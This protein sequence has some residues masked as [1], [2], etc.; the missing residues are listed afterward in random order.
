MNFRDVELLSAYLDGQLSPSEAARLESRLT[1]DPRLE[2]ILNDLRTARTV[3]RALPSRKAPRNFTLRPNMRQLTAPAPPAFPML[4]FASV[5]ASLMF[6]VTVAINTL[7]PLAA[8]RLAA[9]PAPV[10]GFGGGGPPAEAA[11]AAA[12]AEAMPA[13]APTQAP[14][15]SAPAPDLQAQTQKS[16]PELPRAGSPAARPVPL[17]WQ[18]ALA[19][20]AIVLGLFAWYVRSESL[21]RFR[22]RWI[23]Q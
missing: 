18:I 7:A 13:A 15:L 22:Q 17:P 11:T 4:R 3:L 9:A 20:I 16:T 19:G 8:T 21:R 10:Y 6:V 2:A 1:G 23:Q 12:N 14:Q 5:V